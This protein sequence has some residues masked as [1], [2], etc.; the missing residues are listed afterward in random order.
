[1][2]VFGWVADMPLSTQMLK[3]AKDL[4]NQFGSTVI[5]KKP[6]SSTYDIASGQTIVVDGTEDI[7][8]A[9][10]E[11]YSSEEI[12]GLVLVGDIKIMIHSENV[13]INLAEDKIIFNS[14]EYNIINNEPI[15][16][17][18]EIIVYQLQVRK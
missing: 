15:Y 14:V 4:I 10:I 8:K 6:S 12:Q 16:L 7:L 1:M 2:E 11:S 5:L 13:T 3:V 17:Q 18:D 9:N